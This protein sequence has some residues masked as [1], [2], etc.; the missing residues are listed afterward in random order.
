MGRKLTKVAPA[1]TVI[2]LLTEL[3]EGGLGNW[4]EA[5]AAGP[6][7]VVLEVVVAFVVPVALVVVAGLVAAVVALVEVVFVVAPPAAARLAEYFFH[8]PN[9]NKAKTE[10]KSDDAH[11]LR[12]AQ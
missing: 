5:V 2:G 10:E 11:Q 9:R 3:V 7:A 6:A 4:Q 8:Q 12:D 1:L